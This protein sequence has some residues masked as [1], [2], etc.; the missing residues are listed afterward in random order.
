MA[1]P[2][3]SCPHAA[4]PWTCPSVKA[5][6]DAVD[7]SEP[8]WNELRASYAHHKGESGASPPGIFKDIYDR[9]MVLA[10]DCI[11][12]IENNRVEAR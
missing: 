11:T 8:A 2:P 9:M 5:L 12:E 1:K 6:Q 10:S 3:G 4:H 7:A